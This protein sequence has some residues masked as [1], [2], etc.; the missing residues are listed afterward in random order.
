MSPTQPERRANAL[1]ATIHASAVPF[2]RATGML[3]AK[4]ALIVAKDP[5]RRWKLR[6]RIER[7]ERRRTMK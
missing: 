5:R 3:G 6:Y 2:Y 1:V 4:L 7:I